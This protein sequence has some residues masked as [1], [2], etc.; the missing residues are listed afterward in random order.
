MAKR[1]EQRVDAAVLTGDDG[2]LRVRALEDNSLDGYL[3]TYSAHIAGYRVEQ[4]DFGHRVTMKIEFD[5]EPSHDNANLW[6]F[7][8]A[9]AAHKIGKKPTIQV[10]SQDGKVVGYCSFMIWGQVKYMESKGSPSNQF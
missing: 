3:S 2:Y 1:H 8:I 5:N 4:N 9:Q 10:G 7:F 6:T